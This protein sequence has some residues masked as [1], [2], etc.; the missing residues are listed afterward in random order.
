M[1]RGGWYLKPITPSAASKYL[2]NNIS[3]LALNSPY[4]FI[5]SICLIYSGGRGREDT[6]GEDR[7]GL[8]FRWGEGER[9]GG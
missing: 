9:G 2:N 4:V 7:R 8:K 6:G 5:Y 1:A 3:E